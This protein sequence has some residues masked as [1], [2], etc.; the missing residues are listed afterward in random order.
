M[1]NWEERG[2]GNYAVGT[3]T[4]G[5]RTPWSTLSSK[6]VICHFARLSGF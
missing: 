5:R 6:G 4:V 2:A 1:M 3:T